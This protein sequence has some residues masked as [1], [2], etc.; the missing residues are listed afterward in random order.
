MGKTVITID[1]NPLSRT[2]RKATISIVDNLTRALDNMVKFAREIKQER[3]DELV[4]L[5]MTYD[6]KRVLSEA[7]SEIQEHL[8]TIIAEIE[9]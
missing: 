2:S 1:L 6:N 7:I 4:K 3:K 9:Y 8:K 5:I